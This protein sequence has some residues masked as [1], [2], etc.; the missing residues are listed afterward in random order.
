M[1]ILLIEDDLYFASQIETNFKKYSFLNRIEYRKSYEEYLSNIPLIP[2]FDII[3]L[4]IHLGTTKNTNGFL[5]L[6]HIRKHY[7]KIP[8]IIISGH[9][10]YNFLETAFEYGAHDYIIKPFR[11]RE[12]QIRIER[13]FRNYI[14]LEYFSTSTF[15]SYHDI[16]YNVSSYEFYKQEK[17]IILSRSNKYLLSL[18]FIHREKVLSQ[19]FLSD[20]IWGASEKEA[21]KNLRIKILRL[22]KELK[23]VWLDTWIKNKK[24]EWYVFE[25]DLK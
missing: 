13:W 18:F 16:T 20:K 5:I 8:I 19:S 11:P 7:D 14:F 24:G 25:K 15:L 10:E 12:L 2:S 1:N 4:D 22:K 21:D 3:L 9:C 6:K 17:K 23:S